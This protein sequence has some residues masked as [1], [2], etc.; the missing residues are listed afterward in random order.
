MYARNTEDMAE[1][2]GNTTEIKL[3]QLTKEKRKWIFEGKQSNSVSN[4][5]FTDLRFMNNV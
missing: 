2:A 3:P 4:K 5:R 1:A